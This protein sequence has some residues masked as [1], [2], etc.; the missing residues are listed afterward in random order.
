MNNESLDKLTIC[1]ITDS[2][3]DASNLY[4]RNIILVLKPSFFKKADIPLKPI[5]RRL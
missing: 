3:I 5:S 2:S 1:D 4:F